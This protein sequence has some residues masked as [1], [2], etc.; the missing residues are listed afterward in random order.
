MVPLV[1]DA[2][3]PTAL[4]LGWSDMTSLI[5]CFNVVTTTGLVKTPED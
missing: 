1:L 2:D 3:I 4:P 5:S